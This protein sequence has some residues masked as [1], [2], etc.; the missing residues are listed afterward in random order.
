[1]NNDPASVAAALRSLVV[2]AVCAVIAIVIGVLMT[3]PMTYS[4]MDFMAALC[5]VLLIPIFIKWHRPIMI[6]SWCMPATAFFVKGSPSLCLLMIALSITATCIE[7]AMGQKRFM[8]VPQIT[9]PLLFLVAVVAFTAKMTGGI[10]LRAFGSDVYGGKKYVF[11]IVAIL[12]YF[13]LTARPIPPQKARFYVIL[14]FSGGLLCVIEDFYPIVPGF[15]HPIY[16]L[17]PPAGYSFSGPFELGVTR[18]AG[19]GAAATALTNVMLAR[20]GLR[21]IFLSDKM[22]RPV[23]F[24]IAFLLIFMGGFRSA[25][26]GA[27]ITFFMLFF[28]E[29]LHRSRMLPFVVIFMLACAGAVVPLG[30]KLPYTFQRALCFLPDSVVHLSPDARANA[31]DSWQWRVNMWESLLPQIP[32]HLLVG[33]GYAISREDF[34]SEMGAGAAVK[35]VDPA[36]QAL[37][38]SS[39]YHN[40]PLSVI[41]PFGIWGVIGFVW[42]IWAALWVMY[43]NYR[44]CI[45]EL[46]TINTL[47]FAT[48][49]MMTISF[50]GGSLGTG[51]AG[52]TGLLGLSVAINHGVCRVPARVRRTI[53]FAKPVSRAGTQPQPLPPG[54]RPGRM[55]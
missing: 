18:L 49:M 7:R 46:K 25:I 42:F 41:L 19:T 27:A 54:F 35:S 38:L 47:L 40:G 22:W 30:A 34:Q 11:L 48:F 53:P 3:N 21:G 17:I 9:W 16:W 31:E 1:M 33:K 26:I 45:P 44:Y 37:A 55:A 6:A 39:D 10:G 50:Y 20:Y 12:G 36:Q 5:A 28:L 2:Y 13:A 8:H 15:L 23:V 4:T 52:F 51:M 29:G 14:F 43:R 24:C 32:K